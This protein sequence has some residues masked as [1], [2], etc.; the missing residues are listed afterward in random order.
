M[1]PQTQVKP[2]M[3]KLAIKKEKHIAYFLKRLEG[4]IQ[5][6][7]NTTI[8]L[9]KGI[10][11]ILDDIHQKEIREAQEMKKL[12]L[13]KVKN[14]LISKYANEIV[15]LYTEKELGVRRI[16][17]WLWDTHR[18]KISYSSIYRFLQ[19]QNLIRKKEQKNG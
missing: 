10:N 17:Q 4:W 2:L 5:A 1:L 15:E 19:S 3:K 16:Q 9:A 8:S 14:R 18:A 6:N 12:N 7:G 13:S 11:R